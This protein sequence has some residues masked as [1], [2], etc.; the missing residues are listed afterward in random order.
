MK[1]KLLSFCI[2]LT[3]LSCKKE[4][5]TQ[6][7]VPTQNQKKIGKWYND[8]TSLSKVST[9]SIGIF[10]AK[11]KQAATDEPNEY[12]AM[13][14][15]VMGIQ[16]SNTSSYT[17]ALK[18]Y[19]KSIQLLS[20]SNADTLKAMS[21][22]GIG[23]V[24]NI[25]GDYPKALENLYK[26]LRIYEK[27]N[28]KIGICSVNTTLGEVYFQKDN[29]IE[30]KKHLEIA[31][32]ALANDKSNPVYLHATHILA[33]VYGMTG[34]F[35]NALKIDAMG[36]RITDSTANLKIKTSF[37]DNK[38]NCFLF[39]NKIDSAQYYFNECLKIDIKIG[40]KKQIADTYSNL[41]AMFSM[42]NDFAQAEK[43]TLQSIAIL[44]SIDGKPNLIKSY[45]ILSEVYSK[46]KQF[47]KAYTIQLKKHE[48][49]ILM[50]TA[51][52]VTA[53]AEFKIVY[54]T[55]KKEAKIQLLKKEEKIKELKITRRNYL[56]LTFLIV[57]I[58]IG[59]TWYFWKS[60]QQLRNKLY[61]ERI[62]KKTEEHE[63]IRMAKDIH[64]D[65]GSG[66][67][68]INFLSEIILQKTEH[69]PEV[70]ASS[71]AIKATAMKMI[72]NMRDLIW[73]LNPENTTIANLIA[74]MREYT[75]D[76]LDDFDI[77]L[78]YDIPNSLPQTT[79]SKES[80]REL[81]MVLKETLNN[82][83]KHSKAKHVFFSVNIDTISLLIVIKD[84]G[85][86]FDKPAS[87]NG[88][89]N[90]KSRLNAIEGS[91]EV[92]SNKELGT[93]VKVNILLKKI[94]KE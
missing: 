4:V 66:L 77:E 30:A 51:K 57:L 69:L 3:F 59:L 45:D 21:Y 55:Q 27:S 38:A 13:S 8:M 33:N 92:V 94:S 37:L 68:K 26:S 11:I 43:Y 58:S 1:I 65:L 54:E 75:T 31:L 29:P 36:I 88:L 49:Y 63:R 61:E 74:R 20:K 56:I 72:D 76:Y 7:Q 71:E 81:F 32:K 2:F 62:I 73:A 10:A 16:S 14:L 47:E 50:M 85:I 40:N 80:H 18:Y 90:M 15:I 17:L 39:S 28:H 82:I 12:K 9:D 60:K 5:I 87:G 79:I 48:N 89:K 19:E 42:K 53:E 35:E 70:K 6:S 86:G 67:S 52:K 23:T 93:V 22:H 46:Q 44:Q 25:T 83:T 41:G 91:F 64:D 24:H 84:D 34:D 78:H